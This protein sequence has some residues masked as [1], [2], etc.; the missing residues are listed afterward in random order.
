MREDHLRGADELRP[1]EVGSGLQ[2]RSFWQD[3]SQL[4]LLYPHES[5]SRYS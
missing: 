3:L 4:K 1:A 5:T 2:V